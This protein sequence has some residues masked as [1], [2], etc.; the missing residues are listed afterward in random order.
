MRRANI[1]EQKTNMIACVNDSKKLTGERFWNHSTRSIPSM[2]RVI[3]PAGTRRVTFEEMGCP[4]YGSQFR[5]RE[6]QS[7]KPLTDFN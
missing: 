3:E 5:G 4:A 2:V 6:E 1:S 7:L